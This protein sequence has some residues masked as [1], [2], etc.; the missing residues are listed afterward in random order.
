[1]K[2]VLTIGGSDPTGGAGI[3][4]DL[5]VFQTLGVW[6]LSCITNVTVQTSYGVQKITKIPPHIVARQIDAA[7]LDI[8]VDSCKIG[9]LFAPR[10]V[11]VVAERIRRRHIENVVLDPIIWAKDGRTLLTPKAFR[12]LKQELLPLAYIVTPNIPEAE[13]LCGFSIQSLSD[14][15]E[16]ARIIHEMG[17]RLVLIKGGHLSSEPVDVFYDG[18]KFHRFPSPRVK[19]IVHGT[20]C[21]LSSAIASFLALG[22]SPLESV[23]SA[24]E[25][26]RSAI[27]KAIPMG[28]GPYHFAIF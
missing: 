17:A 24:I 22:K 16:S 23:A 7:T 14:M 1:M 3:Q 10:T 21:I 5:K 4:L 15:E 18:E 6:G 8:G 2:R 11:S 13:K 28:K 19:K 27:E 20:G 9:M 12:R 25:F 26:T